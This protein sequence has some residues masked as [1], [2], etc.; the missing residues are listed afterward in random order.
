MKFAFSKNLIKFSIFNI[1]GLLVPLI[2]SVLTIPII[3]K[4]LGSEKFGVFSLFMVLIGYFGLL[5]FGLGKATTRFM[6]ISYKSKISQN[7]YFWTSLL[8]SIGV[9]FLF[10]IVG[11]YLNNIYHLFNYLKMEKNLIDEFSTLFNFFLISMPLL[12]ANNVL[13]GGLE[14]GDHFKIININHAFTE[15]L[16]RIFPLLIVLMSYKFSVIIIGII[17]IKLVSVIFYFVLCIKYIPSLRVQFNFKKK[18][19]LDLISYGKWLLISSMI[20]PL[21]IYMDR[22]VI[23]SFLSVKQLP[24]YTI[25]F[26][27]IRKIQAIPLSIGRA[28]FPILSQNDFS[29]NYL[30]YK[31]S[32]IILYIMMAPL[33][34]IVFLFSKDILLIWLGS[35]FAEKSSIL[36]KIISIGVFFNAV[37]KPAY[38]YIQAV[39]RTDITA[40]AH[41]IELPVYIFSLYLLLHNYGIIGVPIAWVGRII[42]DRAIL[43]IFTENKFGDGIRYSKIFYFESLFIILIIICSIIP[44]S[45]L[46]MERVGFIILSLVV[47]LFI[48]LRYLLS[49]QEFKKKIRN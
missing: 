32:T 11:F 17:L 45:E 39:G 2:I 26:D 13:I 35:E 38:T 1:L 34:L 4:N 3:V 33:F 29:E 6:R 7:G 22:F 40:K 10:S 16:I 23:G 46:F 24:F 15:S 48:V 5:D 49:S 21:M 25:P 42:I 36:L 31:S 43:L 8:I 27:T 20:G 18:I 37:S 47:L 41:L 30:I 12:M 14:S 44:F 19:L 9:G 28:I